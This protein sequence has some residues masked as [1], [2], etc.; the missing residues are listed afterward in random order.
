MFVVQKSR[1]APVTLL[2]PFPETF[3]EP[4]RTFPDCGISVGLETELETCW[5]NIRNGI[6]TRSRNGHQTNPQNG[7]LSLQGGNCHL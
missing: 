3:P 4:S 5:K 6:E 1:P 7:T 2:L